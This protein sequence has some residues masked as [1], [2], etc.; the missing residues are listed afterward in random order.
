M[1]ANP[2]AAAS[3]GAAARRKPGQPDPAGDLGLGAG[4]TLGGLGVDFEEMM[5]V[6][7]LQDMLSGRKADGSRRSGM[8][9]A[10]Y[11]HWQLVEANRQVGERIREEE[12]ALQRRLEQSKVAYHQARKAKTSVGKGQMLITHGAVQEYRG[13]LAVQGAAGKAEFEALRAKHIR[14]KAEWISYGTRQSNLHGLEQKKRVLESRAERFQARRNAALA[15]KRETEAR[16]AAAQEVMD[17]QLEEKKLRLERTRDGLPTPES[18]AEAREFFAKQKREAAAE[19]RRSE[20][21]WES[22]RKRDSSTALARAAANRN[23]AMNT[24]KAAAS[25]RQASMEIRSQQAKEIKSKLKDLE[26]ERQRVV[27]SSSSD[28]KMHHQELYEKKFVT[29]ARAEQFDKSEYG[30]L[31]MRTRLPEAMQ[32]QKAN[33]P[34]RNEQSSREADDGLDDIL[35]ASSPFGAGISSGLDAEVDPLKAD[36]PRPAWAEPSTAAAHEPP[37]PAA[38]GPAAPGPA[39]PGPAAPGPAAPGPAVPG[40]AAPATNET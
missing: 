25:N 35:P 1:A 36:L 27:K 15:S 34:T 26:G 9:V 13:H 10:Q 23:M 3:A 38:P 16:K 24:R 7:E 4:D 17:R 29:E 5:E 32:P 2:A 37:G 18:L 21:G 19:V 12:A 6:K 8:S 39:A 14:Q 28:S 22:D 40:P 11:N 30:M 33:S 20:K 31:L